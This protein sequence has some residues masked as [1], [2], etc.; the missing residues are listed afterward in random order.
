MLR[1][2]KYALRMLTKAPVFT[3]VVVL[4]LALGIGANTAIFT[5]VNAV[6]LKPLP[7]DQPQRLV[8]I[9]DPAR[10][11]GMSSGSPRSD[12]FPYPLYREFV[13][14]NDV[15]TELVGAATVPRITVE[16]A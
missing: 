6:L 3:L 10:V 16:S 12:I 8:I 5:L 13:R 14:R 7:V 1:D 4:T 9:G 2:L 15:L 11:H